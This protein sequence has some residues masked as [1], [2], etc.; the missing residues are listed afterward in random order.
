MLDHI[1][2][3]LADSAPVP[4]DG[5]TSSS[6]TLPTDDSGLLPSGPPLPTSAF[7]FCLFWLLPVVVYFLLDWLTQQRRRTFR[8][9]PALPV[10]PTGPERGAAGG[11]AA[12]AEGPSVLAA[13]IEHSLP[14]RNVKVIAGGLGKVMDVVA[15]H[16]PT[17]ITMVHPAVSGDGDDPRPDAV[18]GEPDGDEP[19]LHVVVDGRREE[20][21]V[22]RYSGASSG[23]GLP[24][25]QFLLLLHPLFLK[26]SRRCLYPNPM[27]RAEVLAFFSLWNQAVG[28]LLVRLRPHIFHCPDFHTAV[29]PWYALPQHPDLRML[30]VLHNAEYQGTISTDQIRG[31]KVDRIASIFNLSADKVQK[32]LVLDGRFNM[33]KAAVDFLLEHQ[34]GVGACAVSDH[35]ALEVRQLYGLLWRLPTVQGLENPM[36]EDERVEWDD[37]HSRR[38]AAKA[39]IQRQLGLREDPS[40][41]L[42]VSLGRLVRQK[43][44]D[45]LAD[46]APW[47]LEKYPDAQLVIVGPVG[48]GF[49][50]YAGHH[51]QGLAEDE[52][53]RGRVFVKCEFQK[54]G[55]DLR[56]AADFCLMPSRDEPFGYVDVEFAW[57]GAL[58]VGAQA[59]GLG[60]VPGFYYVAQNRENLS[61]LRR[62]LRTRGGL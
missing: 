62:E 4:D 58:V 49:G 55:D 56:F 17:E 18:Y 27:S 2:G 32:H 10:V 8:G 30:L 57:C 61:R 54:V 52:R 46:V 1:W 24:Q 51:L 21:A 48:D 34:G 36:L 15:Q 19:P 50:H 11:R 25:V 60:K 38:A 35:Y 42:F 26:R 5:I 3:T 9:A 28:A 33:L 44:V 45:L 12:P 29:A 6:S 20:V 7:W 53:F 14:H 43:G 22:R 16:H 39:T 41:K 13:S 37:L 59:G 23:P 40:A 47:L 31:V